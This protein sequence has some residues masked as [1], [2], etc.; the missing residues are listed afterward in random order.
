MASAVRGGRVIRQLQGRKDEK[1]R[2]DRIDVVLALAL[3]QD[4][5]D[6]GT[7]L[8]TIRYQGGKVGFTRR[9]HFMSLDWTPDNIFNGFVSD[10]TRSI[11]CMCRL[12][13]AEAQ[14]EIAQPG[15][16]EKLSLCRVTA[17]RE[18]K[19]QQIAG[20]VAFGRERAFGSSGDGIL[21]STKAGIGE[22]ERGRTKKGL[23]PNSH[24]PLYVP[25]G[26]RGI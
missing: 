8:R 20:A 21:H 5:G 7:V 19:K 17:K 2:V 9:K 16:C 14:A 15:W 13:V 1:G 24:N 26:E 11:S 23:R 6:F 25:G 10:I 22:H 4:W 12:S 3:S 18:K